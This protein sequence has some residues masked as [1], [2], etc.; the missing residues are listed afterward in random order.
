MSKPATDEIRA[1]LERY[2]PRLAGEPIEFLGEGW[3]LWVFTAG[4]HVLRFPK[5]KD[6][7]PQLVTDASLLPELARHVSLAIPVP[8][9]Y[10]D[11]GPN[12]LPFAGHP[13]IPGISLI[14]AAELL[15]AAA[16]GGNPELTL[17]A[18]FGRDLGVFLRELH[19]FPPE[20]ALEL[21]ARLV[22]GPAARQERIEMYEHIVRGAFPLLGCEARTYVEQRFEA[23]VND[24]A[25][26]VFEPRLIHGDLDRQ[27]TL[28]DPQTGELTGVIDFGDKDVGNPA[29]DLWMPLLDFERL[30]IGNQRERF[31]EAYGAEHV[32][33]ERAQVEVE[34]IQFTWPLHDILYGLRIGEQEFVEGGIRALNQ[35]VPRELRCP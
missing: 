4:D 29:S 5:H 14:T 7:A 19:A 16:R 1:A 34:F 18:N 27:N 35:D 24:P 10:G 30:G 25:N 6:A 33:L 15:P 22:D 3:S 13:F 2:A 21:G 20:R 11:E 9:V 28:V 32:D 26:F 12:G 8:D 17:S 31:L 23:H